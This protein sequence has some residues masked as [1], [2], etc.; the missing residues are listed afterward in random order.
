MGAWSFNLVCRSKLFAS[1]ASYAKALGLALGFVNKRLGGPVGVT[2]AFLGSMG[3]L[4]AR[5]K[6]ALDIRGEMGDEGSRAAPFILVSNRDGKGRQGHLDAGHDK[7]Y[8]L[9]AIV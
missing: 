4:R 6:A 2:F 8:V 1:S 5:K 7:F 9:G 3:G